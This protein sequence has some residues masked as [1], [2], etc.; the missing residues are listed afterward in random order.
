MGGVE[1]LEDVDA[2]PAGPAG[3]ERA[4][5]QLVG[6]RRGQLTLRAFCVQACSLVLRG[7]LAIVAKPK[8][9]ARA[10]ASTRVLKRMLKIKLV[11]GKRVK[12]TL[13][14]TAPIR[15]AILVANPARLY[16]F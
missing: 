16:Q 11:A 3:L 1:G 7:K 4:P 14:L 2:D 8:H 6:E 10:K 9:G 13:K 5:G 12:V 15:K